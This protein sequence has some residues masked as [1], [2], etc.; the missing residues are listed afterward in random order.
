MSSATENLIRK[1]RAL[2]AKASDPGVT[3]AESLAYSE[4]VQELLA[5]HNM[6]MA[7]IGES[8]DEKDDVDG[9]TVNETGAIWKNSQS[10]KILLRAVCRFYM[11]TAVGPGRGMKTWTIVGRPSNVRV[12]MEMTEYLIKTTIRL[13]TEYGKKN[14]GMGVN[15]I[16]FRRGCMARLSERLD[17]LRKEQAAQAKVYKSDGNPG[18]LPALYENSDVLARQYMKAH[19]NIKFS[20]TK[21]PREGADAANGRAAAER[22]GLNP[23][24]G[25]RSGGGRLMIGSR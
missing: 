18:N 19:M 17:E 4:K 25:G 15:V 22:V 11:C 7:D 8:S 24:V 20:R 10:R 14:R 23:Q 13:S 2:M 9:H 21:A 3:E 6:A 16:D 1:I 12:A 5:K